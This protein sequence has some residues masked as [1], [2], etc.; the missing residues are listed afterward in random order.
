MNNMRNKVASESFRPPRRRKICALELRRLFPPVNET[1]LLLLSSKLLLELLLDTDA[2]HC[3]ECVV[4]GKSLSLL[5]CNAMTEPLCPSL[6]RST[7][8]CFA[9]LLFSM[10]VV[11]F[12]MVPVT[13]TVWCLWLYKLK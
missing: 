12:V 6:L 11:V 7:S 8:R 4:K 10:F 5:T 13:G 1:I 2:L 3:L 9:F